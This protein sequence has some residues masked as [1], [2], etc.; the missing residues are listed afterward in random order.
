MAMAMAVRLVAL[1]VAYRSRSVSEREAQQRGAQCRQELGLLGR[2]KGRE[3]GMPLH[4]VD[5]L[6]HR[7]W[8]CH[9]VRHHLVSTYQRG[10]QT[11]KYAAFTI[12]QPFLLV[13][14][15]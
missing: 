9:M 15:H 4:W 2:V 5:A 13:H 3:L 12:I 7:E 11:N 10:D 8:C 1:L 14:P 6:L